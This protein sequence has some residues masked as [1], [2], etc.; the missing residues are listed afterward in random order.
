MPRIED[1]SQQVG[2]PGVANLVTPRANQG[3]AQLGQEAGQLDATLENLHQG[4][5]VVKGATALAD[6]R[7]AREK[8]QIEM[9]EGAKTP[10]GFSDAVQADFD[11]A[12]QKLMEGQEDPYV[13][14]FLESRLKGLKT[15]EASEAFGWEAATRYAGI[16]TGIDAV[17]NKNANGVFAK[18]RTFDDVLDET[19]ASIEASGL[20]LPMRERKAA[21]A[22][23]GLARSAVYGQIEGDPHGILKQL[24][25]G[26]WDEFLDNDNK[27]SAVNAAQGEIK[28]RESEAKANASMARQEALFDVGQWANDNAAS[29]QLTGKAV[30]SPYSDDQLKA[31]LKPK[32]YDAM[33]HSHAQAAALFQATGDMRS[34]TPAEMQATVEK[35]KPV[36]G[37]AGFA[38][39]EKIYETA[40]KVLENTIKA[41]KADPGLA[42]REAFVP[43]KAAWQAFEKS[44]APEDLQKA[45]KQSQA[46][47]TAMG[48]PASEQGLMPHQMS[49]AIAGSIK[50]AKP[51]DAAKQLQTVATTF[52]PYWNHAFRQMSNLLDGHMKVAAIVPDSISAALLVEGSR[53]PVAALRKALGVKDNDIGIARA[54]ADDNRVKALATSLSQRAGGSSTATQVSASIEVLALQRMRAYGEDQGT[55]TEAAIK[56]VVEDKYDFAQVGR[57]AFRVPRDSGGDAE[58]I[59]DGAR[60]FQARITGEGIDLPG[61]IKGSLPQ[62]TRAAYVSA[63]QRNSY[64][65][66]N[67]DETGA[68][69]YSER[70][71]PVTRGGEPVSLTWAQL[72]EQ[73]RYK[74]FKNDR[75]P[76]RQ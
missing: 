50:G 30:P 28:R 72:Q 46:A 59:G 38:D 2:G 5:A 42:A 33:K 73:P 23:A 6:F 47:Q 67:D 56:S 61:D 66:T 29:L 53:Q 21:A 34:Q 31:L 51:E 3:F 32:Q 44:Q 14:T 27:I 69:L 60:G 58:R 11:E 13:Q 40:A 39:Q 12:S 62:D 63:L 24:Q 22:K 9:R 26:T 48:V 76:E 55:A 41:R 54:V 19:L 71:V 1:L 70:G 18:P 35:L 68:I 74:R 8:R 15:Q 17:T 7:V 65:V 37:Q 45:L 25:A 4:E 57:R 75:R 43:V 36:D 10:E 52:G 20:P 49:R 64:W 16:E